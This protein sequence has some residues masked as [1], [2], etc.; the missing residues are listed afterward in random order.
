MIPAPRAFHVISC[1]SFI[2]SQEYLYSDHSYSTEEEA[3]AGR[4][5]G[6][7]RV[8][9]L[10]EG[11]GAWQLM[12]GPAGRSPGDQAPGRA[13]GAPQRAMAALKPQR[14]REHSVTTARAVSGRESPSKPALHQEKAPNYHSF[15]GHQEVLTG[16]Q[17]TF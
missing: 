15:C 9:E 13:H 5:E 3:G 17:S 11:T 6:T 14:T 10:V 12:P 2:K 4:S 16:T 8:T 7:C 1:N